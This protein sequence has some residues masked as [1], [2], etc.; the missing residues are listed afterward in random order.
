MY[1]EFKRIFMFQMEYKCNKNEHTDIQQ[2]TVA[3]TY[4]YWKI[5]ATI[6]R[7]FIADNICLY[8]VMFVC[9]RVY[10]KRQNF[11]ISLF[12]AVV[13]HVLFNIFL[14][15]LLQAALNMKKCI[16]CTNLLKFYSCTLWVLRQLYLLTSWKSIFNDVKVVYI[17]TFNIY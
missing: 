6:V 2:H 7:D 8:T 15:F 1:N 3:T 13:A 11:L 17:V 14:F 12:V 4:R 16:C 5:R 10:I 9:I